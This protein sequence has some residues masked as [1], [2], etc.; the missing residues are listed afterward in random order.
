MM[1]SISVDVGGSARLV[2]GRFDAERGEVLVHGAD[3]ARGQGVDRLA[4]LL[5]AADDLVVDIR[6]IAHVGDAVAAGAQPAP[7]HVERHHHP[8]V[9][10]V[11]VVVDG[12]AADVHA[13][14]ARTQRNEFLL[15]AAEAVV[16]L[17]DYSDC[18]AAGLSLECSAS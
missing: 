14:F 6:D 7:H 15:G 12:H 18:E 17:Q 13:N 8:G 10:E 4:V 1:S 16:D 2:V 5:R 11:A 9:A 3:E